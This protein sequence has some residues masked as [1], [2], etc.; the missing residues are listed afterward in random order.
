[1]TS[2]SG[3][4][5]LVRTQRSQ[6]KQVAARRDRGRGSGNVSRCGTPGLGAGKT[7]CSAHLT[8]KR[9]RCTLTLPLALRLLEVLLNHNFYLGAAL[10]T[11][12]LAAAL[13]PELNRACTVG[14]TWVPRGL[15][16]SKFVGG[17]KSDSP[18]CPKRIAVRSASSTG[19][20]CQLSKAASSAAAENSIQSCSK[21]IVRPHRLSIC[22]LTIL[23][24]PDLA[25]SN[26]DKLPS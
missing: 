4:S 8:T 25:R 12:S 6:N 19:H 11:A 13:I 24:G 23:T 26:S 22:G 18:T 9:C 14:T 7:Q 17:S 5:G 1:M 16:T 21:D 3:I 20:I 10:V 2:G 15:L